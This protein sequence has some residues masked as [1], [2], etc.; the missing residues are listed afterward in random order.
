M[1]TMK[2]EDIGLPAFLKIL[3]HVFVVLVFKMLQIIL[4][5]F[6]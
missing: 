4:K 5:D 2:S 1:K 6:F 3:K